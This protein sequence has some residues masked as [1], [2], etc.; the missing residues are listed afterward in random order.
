MIQRKYSTHSKVLGAGNFGKV[1]LANSIAD[2]EFR[3][4][5]KTLPK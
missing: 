2:P 1:F 5:I 4:A 3:V